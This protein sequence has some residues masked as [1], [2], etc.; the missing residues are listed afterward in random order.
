MEEEILVI[1]YKWEGNQKTVVAFDTYPIEMT[2]QSVKERAQEV[3][4]DSI[5]IDDFKIIKVMSS[6]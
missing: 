4:D 2:V 5:T 3:V 1:F 6:Y